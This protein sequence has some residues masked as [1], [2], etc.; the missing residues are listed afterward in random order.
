M[1]TQRLA[2]TQPPVESLFTWIKSGEIAI[3]EI[4]RPFVRDA[5]KGRDVLDSL[6]Q[7]YPAS[8]LVAWKNPDVEPKDG[9]SS[10]GSHPCRSATHH[11]ADGAAVGLEGGE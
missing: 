8:L 3:P 1:P 10:T 9:I 5:A 2:V 11:G 6:L 4:P 7:S